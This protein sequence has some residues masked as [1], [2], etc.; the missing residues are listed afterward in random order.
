MPGDKCH[1]FAKRCRLELPWYGKEWYNSCKERKGEPG[2]FR[3]RTMNRMI[4]NLL[5]FLFG[6]LFICRE[7]Q[8]TTPVVSLVVAF[9]F[10]TLA[11]CIPEDGKGKQKLAFLLAVYGIFS[12]F[13]PELFF[14]LPLVVYHSYM[15]QVPWAAVLILPYLNW[16]TARSPWDII[17]CGLICVVALWSSMRGKR[18]EQLE[19]DMIRMRD[20]D[21]ERNLVLKEKNKNL[22]EKQDYEIYLATLRER[23]RIAREIHDNVGHMLSRSILQVGALGTVH[24]E[25]PLHGQLASVNDTLNQ[26]MNSIRESVHDLHD[27]SVDLRQ[28]VLDA[29]EVMKET[30]TINVDYDMSRTVPRK[31]KYCFITTVKEAVNNIVKHSNANKVTIVLREHPGFYQLSV[32]DNGTKLP[33]DLSGGI[34]ISNMRERV[35]ALNGTLHIEKKHGFCIFISI[36]KTEDGE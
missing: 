11:L 29:V 28:A 2:Y 10:G 17:C 8:F 18:V 31:V 21:V 13:L 3:R 4:D 7:T 9:I 1:D 24:K 34:G 23:N 15:K 30:Y 5:L 25:E 19:E 14:F 12:F 26:A 32:E 35:E 27:D 16:L 22:M 33:E 6:V 20:E 36:K